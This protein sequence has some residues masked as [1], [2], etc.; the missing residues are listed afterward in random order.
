[1]DAWESLVD[2]PSEHQFDDCFKKFEIVCSPWPIFVDYVNQTWIIFHKEKFVKFWMNKVM[3]LGN[4][5][6]NRY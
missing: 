3:H 6:I 2:C 1:M 4:T 5:T